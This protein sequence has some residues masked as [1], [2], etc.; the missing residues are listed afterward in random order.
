MMNTHDKNRSGLSH[1]IE[2]QT[3][4]RT[5]EP[6]SRS[7]RSLGTREQETAIEPKSYK[8]LVSSGFLLG[9]QLVF[10]GSDWVSSWYPFFPFLVSPWSP[11]V[12]LGI[13]YV[14]G[15]LSWLLL[16]FPF[17]SLGLPVVS[18]WSPLL[19]LVY[20]CS[21]FARKLHSQTGREPERMSQRAREPENQRARKAES[22]RHPQVIHWTPPEPTGS[23]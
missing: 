9:L 15:K 21:P 23:H 20:L 3:R 13:P 18:S 16:G 19:P 11:V 1:Y 17:R 4:Q 6:E 12:S 2:A 8:L 5:R 14:S 10:L 22:Q 7:A